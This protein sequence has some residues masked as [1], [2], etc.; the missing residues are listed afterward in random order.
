[1]FAP[2]PPP[3]SIG[4]DPGVQGAGVGGPSRLGA[5]YPLTSGATIKGPPWT[6][7]S[8]S[9]A[10]AMGAPVLPLFLG[11]LLLH[12]APTYANM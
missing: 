11:L 10:T 7:L 8:P 1:M 3:P 6:P 9:P 4:V 5:G 12:V 2:P